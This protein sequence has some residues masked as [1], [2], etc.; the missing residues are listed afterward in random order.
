MTHTNSI[1]GSDRYT[2]L[3]IPYPD[4]ALVCDGH[5]EGTGWFPIHREE[6]DPELLALWQAA[7]EARPAADGWHFV[8]CPKCAGTGKHRA[9]DPTANGGTP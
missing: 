8:Q 1:E 4:P 3:G 7:E 6:T 2:A 5:C 9:P